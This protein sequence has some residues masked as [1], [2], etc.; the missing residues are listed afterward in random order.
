MWDVFANKSENFGSFATHSLLSLTSTQTIVVVASMHRAVQF[1][2]Y[3]FLYCFKLL[4]ICGP[5]VKCFD[6]ILM[7]GLTNIK[8]QLHISVTESTLFLVTL[9]SLPEP[10]YNPITAMGLPQ[11]LPFSWTTLRA[12]DPNM[13]HVYFF[14][15]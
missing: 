2:N 7:L 9:K 4:N 11:C 6:I 13:W 8:H 14:Q 1:E 10:I 12:L 3:F 5:C 15:T